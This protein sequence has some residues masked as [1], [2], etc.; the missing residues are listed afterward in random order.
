MAWQMEV[1]VSA[2]Q[3]TESGVGHV[4][5]MDELCRIDEDAMKQAIGWGISALQDV[6][7]NF[8]RDVVIAVWDA[9]ARSINRDLDPER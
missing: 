1:G 7:G 4:P 9:M 8:K 5:T 2:E 6:E 3:T